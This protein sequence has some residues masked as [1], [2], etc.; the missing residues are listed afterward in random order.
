MKVSLSLA[1]RD[2]R[3]VLFGISVIGSLLLGAR[4]IP[5]VR[6]METRQ[7]TRL[8]ALRLQSR[9]LDAAVD[10]GPKGLEERRRAHGALRGRCFVAGSPAEATTALVQRVSAIAEFAGASVRGASPLGASLATDGISRIAIRVSLTGNANALLELLRELDAD[11]ALLSVQEVSVAQADPTAA[12]AELEHLR[13]EITIAAI[14]L[15][16]DPRSEA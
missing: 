11:T 16:P 9:L 7:L 6:T 13:I 2:R 8:D 1:P 14:A 3:A 12:T 5:A 15:L 4:G 10:G